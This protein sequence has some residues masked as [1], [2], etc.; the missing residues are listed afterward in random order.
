MQTEN[1]TVNDRINDKMCLN[2]TD[3][4]PDV[5]ELSELV[6]H[7]ETDEHRHGYNASDEESNAGGGDLPKIELF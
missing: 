2:D 6:R 7:Y 1:V 3:F 4:G 5:A